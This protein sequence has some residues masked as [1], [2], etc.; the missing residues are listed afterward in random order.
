M[1]LTILFAQVFGIYLVLNGVLALIRQHEM[2]S[3]ARLFGKEAAL[4]YTIAALI[5]LGGLFMVLTYHDW[6]TAAS[7]II[8]LVG[9]L[10]LLK[11]IVFL[12]SSEK[13]AMRIVNSFGKHTYT[14]WGLIVLLVGLYL[15]AV[16]FGL[17]S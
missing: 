14:I 17:V 5:T 7:S 8:T 1:E 9:W 16:G 2:V 4:R 12:F 3:V 15:V 6:S 11:G 10:V 13:Q